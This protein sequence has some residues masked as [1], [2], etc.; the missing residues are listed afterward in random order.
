MDSKSPSESI[1]VTFRL[2][3]SFQVQELYS[4]LA[5]FS[6]QQETEAVGYERRMTDSEIC[7]VLNPENSRQ[8]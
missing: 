1:F 8:S 5:N 3:A 7:E 4:Y 2:I 6:R